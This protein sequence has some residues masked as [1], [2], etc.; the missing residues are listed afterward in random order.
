MITIGTKAQTLEVGDEVMLK[1]GLVYLI[2]FKAYS[3]T[4]I[5]VELLRQGFPSR[6]W[7]HLDEIV[8]KVIY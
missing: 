7:W 5:Q 3:G 4:S 2:K 1:S 8:N 6:T